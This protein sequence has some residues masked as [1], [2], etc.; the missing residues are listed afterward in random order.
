MGSLQRFDP[1]DRQPINQFRKEISPTYQR[2]FGDPFHTDADFFGG[3]GI[4][5]PAFNI[6]EHSDHYM[7]EAE[8]PGLEPEDVEVEVQGDT[9]TIRGEKKRRSEQTKQG[10]V[11]VMES[12]YGMFHRSFVLPN[13]ADPDH[14][15]ADSH[16][17]MLY[18][19]I[20]KN[21]KQPGRK[22]TIRRKNHPER[23]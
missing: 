11:H 13:N 16:N 8:L 22:I 9:L 7:I 4:F 14:I 12:S 10:Q 6:E 15:S 3:R 2:F 1:F 5:M 17:G 23:E 20:P 21:Q 18:I 19:K